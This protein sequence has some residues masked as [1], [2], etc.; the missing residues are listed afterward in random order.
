M[1]NTMVGG[2]GGGDRNAKYIPLHFSFDRI[3]AKHDSHVCFINL[4]SCFCME[5][6]V[7]NYEH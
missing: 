1:Q 5:F 2:G 3:K 6:L 7:R 4:K